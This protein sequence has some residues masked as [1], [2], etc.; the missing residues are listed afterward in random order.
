[1]VLVLEILLMASGTAEWFRDSH[2]HMTF[3]GF[4]AHGWGDGDDS[5]LKCISESDCQS[6][7]LLDSCG[8]YDSF[9]R[10]RYWI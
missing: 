9:A 4:I 5:L 2:I 3:P 6:P 1:M 7:L 8:S 10:V